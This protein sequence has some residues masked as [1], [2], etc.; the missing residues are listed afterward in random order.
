MSNTI[1]SEIQEE[2][3]LS[4]ITI[5]KSNPNLIKDLL[6][7]NAT[8][9]LCPKDHT[10]LGK[11]YE[12]IMENKKCDL[13]KK[14]IPKIEEMFL[15]LKESNQQNRDLKSENK[16][17]EEELED[18][19]YEVRNLKLDKLKLE[20][21]MEDLIWIMSKMPKNFSKSKSKTSFF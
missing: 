14:N 7:D 20:E 13:I 17:L 10:Y 15:K 16:R 3:K 4:D 8:K 1:C 18:K 9:K 6:T 12:L 19:V 2:I 5:F 11:I 21:E